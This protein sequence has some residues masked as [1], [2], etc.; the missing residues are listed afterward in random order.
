MALLMIFWTDHDLSGWGWVT[1]VTGMV[2]FWVLLIALL[3]MVAR[4]LNRPAD[5]AH[6]PRLSPEQL[7]AERFARGDIEEAEYRR[8]LATL[9]GSD[10]VA[11][12][13]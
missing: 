1:M 4:G 3:V 6:G 2:V 10:R 9:T 5:A 7:L 11:P 8:R 13:P 12:T